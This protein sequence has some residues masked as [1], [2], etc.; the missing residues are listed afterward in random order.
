MK[1][2]KLTIKERYKLWKKWKKHNLNSR[3]YQYCVLLGA[4]ESPTFRLEQVYAIYEKR[5]SQHV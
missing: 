3:A 4:I 2:T 5:E 1:K